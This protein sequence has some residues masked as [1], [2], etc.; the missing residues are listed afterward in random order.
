[1]LF[2][3]HKSPI[4]YATVFS[5]CSA[6]IP[7]AFHRITCLSYCSAWKLCASGQIDP[8]G[9]Q[10]VVPVE[11]SSGV[12]QLET[13]GTWDQTIKN[14]E[15]IVVL[16]WKKW[17]WTWFKPWKHGANLGFFIENHGTWGF[18]HISPMIGTW[19]LGYGFSPQFTEIVWFH[20][21]CSFRTKPWSGHN[22][23]G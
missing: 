7:A 19:I 13:D 6:K 20:G 9:G 15:K 23:T 2:F 8:K 12:F 10:G 1:M 22:I 21:E 18:Q 11:F 4:K 17:W 16:P 14:G 5:S 3:S